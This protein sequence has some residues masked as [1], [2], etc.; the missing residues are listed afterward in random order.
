MRARLVAFSSFFALALTACSNDLPVP[1]LRQEKLLCVPTSAAMILAFYG[2]SESPRKLKMMA[3]GERYDPDARFDSFSI[4]RYADIIHAVQKLGYQWTEM[5]LPDD[6]QGFSS[7][8][9]ILKSEIA[10]GHPV[11]I[12]L[13]L[14]YG[15]TVVVTGINSFAKTISIVDPNQPAP[16]KGN[17]G[18]DQ[19]EASWNEH[20]YGNHFRSLIVTQQKSA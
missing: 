18:F 11:M 14:P 1:H 3:L 19:L 13:T 8:M 12:D 16:G 17:L 10:S 15:H 20:A 4:T 7:G 6:D 9:G 2:D 5:T